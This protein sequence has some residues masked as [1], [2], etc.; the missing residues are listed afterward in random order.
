[1]LPDFPGPGD[2]FSDDVAVIGHP[3]YWG[4]LFFV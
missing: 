3:L 4:W 1:M 2:L